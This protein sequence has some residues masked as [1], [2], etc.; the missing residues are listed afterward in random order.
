MNEAFKKGFYK[1][2]ALAGE[3][4]LNSVQDALIGRLPF[5]TTAST[6]FGDRPKGHSRGREWLG[7][8]GG[9]LAGGVAGALGGLALGGR[10]NH[11]AMNLG[12]LGGGLLGEGAASHVINKRNYDE[13]G[14]L[15]EQPQG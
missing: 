11:L 5:G 15:K 2:A 14:D 12:A 6:I 3:H 7:R 9:G 4:G 8:V 10:N 1:A 13:N